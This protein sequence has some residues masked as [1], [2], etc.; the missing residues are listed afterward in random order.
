[1]NLPKRLLLFWYPHAAKV[2]VRSWVNTIAVLEED[3]GVGIMWRLIFV[4]MFHDS[5]ITGRIMSFFFRL[6]RIFIGLLAYACATLFFIALALVWFL[7]PLLFIFPLTRVPALLILI[8]GLTLFIDRVALF[9]PIR[10]WQLNP[11]LTND[12]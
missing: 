4:P 10:I 7:F 11:K 9:P 8:F 3:L 12:E 6:G 5:S 2:F 1:M